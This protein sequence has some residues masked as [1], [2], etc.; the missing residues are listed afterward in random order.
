MVCWKYR[1]RNKKGIFKSSFY[2]DLKTIDKI[3]KRNVENGSIIY[4]DAWKGYSNIK[5]I[6]YKHGIVCHTQNFINPGDKEIHTQTIEATWRWLKRYLKTYPS[7]KNKTL[8]IILSVFLSKDK[9]SD[10]Q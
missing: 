1:K 6:G 7:I 9:K 2:R 8:I 3:V 10:F 5:N 4:T